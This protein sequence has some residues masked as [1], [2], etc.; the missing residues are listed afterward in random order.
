MFEYH[1]H[2]TRRSEEVF[3]LEEEITRKCLDLLQQTLDMHPN[4]NI[5]HIG[6]DEVVL[7]NLHPQCREASMDFPTRYIE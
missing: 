7:A 5:I 4:S 6:C 2:S 3:F 1:L